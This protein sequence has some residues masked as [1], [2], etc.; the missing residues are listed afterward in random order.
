[1]AITINHRK[2]KAA[3]K[4]LYALGEE[5]IGMI[6]SMMM[7]NENSLDIAKVIQKDW[8]KYK[9]VSAESLAKQ[10]SRYKSTELMTAPSNQLDPISTEEKMAILQDLG[11]RV[12]SVA[13][14]NE[15]VNIQRNRIMATVAREEKFIMPLSWLSKDIIAMASLLKDLLEMEFDT[16]LRRRIPKTD[17]LHLV[18]HENSESY[19]NYINKKTS[20]QEVGRATMDLLRIVEA[21]YNVIDND[22]ESGAGERRVSNS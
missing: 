10:L 11:D 21:D 9:N 3:F 17:G 7:Q 1:M 16:G 12:D 5:R 4:R 13:C 2:K 22:N 6:N 18:P 19:S 14:M 8:G 15:L 20:F